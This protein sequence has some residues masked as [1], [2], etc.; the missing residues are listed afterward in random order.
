MILTSFL[1]NPQVPCS[2]AVSDT[3]GINGGSPFTSVD[4]GQSGQVTFESYE[5]NVNCYVDIGSSCANGLEVEITYMQLEAYVYEGEMDCDDTIHFAWVNK[6]GETE[7]TDPQ[8]GCLGGG[9]S[10][11]NEHPFYDDDY[12][13]ATEHPTWYRLVGTDVKLV[14]Q[15]DRSHNGGKIQVDWKCDTQTRVPCSTA[16]SDTERIYGGSPFTSVDNGQSGQVTFESYAENVNCY[17]DIGS[18]C[19]NG[20]E[21]E[22]THMELEG[23]VYN[24]PDYTR[25][26]C[27]D[28][29]HFEWVNKDGETVEQT[30]RQ[31]GCLG[32]DHSSC[33]EHPFYRDSISV[34]EQPTEYTLVGT[35]VKLVLKTDDMLSDG[36]I[37]V[38]WKC[39]TRTTTTTVTSSG[40]S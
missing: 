31:C 39:N 32:E 11:C 27:I 23:Y 2:T 37:Q 40:R 5:D 13:W 28:T 6:E 19:A 4:N 17:V 1:A 29:I 16:V 25:L 9:H 8:C 12:M 33:N 7:Q 34:T 36:K 21:V 35:D 18:S 30:N 38:D 20:L 24:Y 26:D 10:S 15:T 22:I 3:G 14:L